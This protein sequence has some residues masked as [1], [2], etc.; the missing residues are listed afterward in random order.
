MART[1]SKRWDRAIA[2]VERP[3]DWGVQVVSTT[4]V[5]KL[6]SRQHAAFVRLVNKLPRTLCTTTRGQVF[7]AVS[8]NELLA[9]LAKRK[10]GRVNDDEL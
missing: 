3:D 5:V 7:E 8:L 9:A 4:E 10:G 1:P 6:L 2:K